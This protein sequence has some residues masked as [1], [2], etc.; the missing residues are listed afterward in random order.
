MWGHLERQQED[1]PSKRWL[2]GPA[3]Y[4][5]SKSPSS[6]EKWLFSE[7]ILN[8]KMLT[9]MALML[10]VNWRRGITWFSCGLPRPLLP[11]GNPPPS[12]HSWN[13]WRSG[14]K[15][16]QRSGTHSMCHKHTE[17]ETGLI[18]GI[19]T[20]QWGMSKRRRVCRKSIIWPQLIL[21]SLL[22][23]PHSCRTLFDHLT[24]L[25]NN[26]LHFYSLG[27]RRQG[28]NRFLGRHLLD[29]TC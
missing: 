10:W 1:L 24:T 8:L 4:F 6:L 27:S 26:T 14:M 17:T 20:L 28:I 25:T 23:W 5:L 7:L 11:S 16:H 29:T 15:C 9:L 22:M 18:R 19:F 12:L 21:T 2:I 3:L 13:R